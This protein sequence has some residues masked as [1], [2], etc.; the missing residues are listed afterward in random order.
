M[1]KKALPELSVSLRNAHHQ[2]SLS[3]TLKDLKPILDLETPT[4]VTIDLSELTFVS[5]APLALMVATIRRGR[6]TGMIFNGSIVYPNSVA[7][8]TLPASHGCLPSSL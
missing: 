2:H 7:A 3:R 6:E 8:R 1:A 5:P 4:S